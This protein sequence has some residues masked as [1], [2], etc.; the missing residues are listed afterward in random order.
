MR[1]L[2]GGMELSEGSGGDGREGAELPDGLRDDAQDVIDVGFSG[3]FEEAEAEAGAGAGFAESHGHEDVAGLG[4][5]GVAGRTAADGGALQVEGDDEGLAFQLIEPEIGGVGDARNGDAIGLAVEARA[6]EGEQLAIDA[7][8]K[9]GDAS[10][11]AVGK[12][13]H[14]ELGG[15]GQADDAGDI[16]SAGAAAALMASAD[17]ER[18]DR[19]A[20]TNI[21]GADTLGSVH[22]VAA[23]GKQV[24]ADLTNVEGHL[25]GGLDGIDVEEGSG[26]GGELGDGF[27]GLEDAGLIVGKHDGDEARRG[28]EGGADGVGRDEAAGRGVNEGDLDAAFSETARGMEDGGVLN[29]G[30]DEVVAGAQ[31]AEEGGVVAL[32]AARVKDNLGFV[33]VEELGKGL[34]GAVEGAAGGLAV[35]VDGRG[36]AE[37]LHPER[38]HGFNHFGKQWGGGVGVHVYAGGRKGI[39]AGLFSGGY[40][41]AE[42]GLRLGA[43]RKASI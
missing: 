33:A 18:I 2:P 21:H 42:S 32:G 26:F 12:R 9:G 23:D 41:G 7:V 8:A 15:A 1:I 38:V 13:V 19:C 31:E 17:E 4:C 43:A 40:H 6:G 14:G 35:K 22:L 20:A 24:A 29:G 3:G 27:N 34:S 16:L 36:V 11:G 28:S 30:G 37:V 39:H 25:A 5:A 10:P